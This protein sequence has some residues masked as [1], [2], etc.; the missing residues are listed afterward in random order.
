MRLLNGRVPELPQHQVQG[1]TKGK[2]KVTKIMNTKLLV[3]AVAVALMA[4]RTALATPTDQYN[5]T[6]AECTQQAVQA[7]D[8]GNV[9][10]AFFSGLIGV[11]TGIASHG[12][13]VI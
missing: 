4:A 11:L 5:L 8:S 7:A 2:L 10:K 12:R 1:L 13:N 3:I 9:G 6:L